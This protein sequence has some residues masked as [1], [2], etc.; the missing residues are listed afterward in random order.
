MKK[1]FLTSFEYSANLNGAEHKT[2]TRLLVVNGY[3]VEEFKERKPD[4]NPEKLWPFEESVAMR[5]QTRWFEQNYPDCTL[6]S[7]FIFPTIDE[8]EE[9]EQVLVNR[10]RESM[11]Y[12]DVRGLLHDFWKANPEFDPT[13]PGRSA[14]FEMAWCHHVD[15]L[16]NRHKKD[17]RVD[18]KA[19]P[20]DDL[21]NRA[22]G[23]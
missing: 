14:M 23:D 10:S 15:V 2:E 12:E 8:I 13:E 21:L 4:Y 19:Y 18:G 16:F 17:E 3:E 9:S 6:H 20:P 5:K 22:Q 7:Q 11:G 1:L